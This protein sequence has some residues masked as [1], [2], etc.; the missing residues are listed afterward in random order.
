MATRSSARDG[1]STATV[2]RI[3]VTVVATLVV[4]YAVY[5]VRS[6]LVLVLV[7][8]FLAAGL[9]PAVRRL[10]GFGLSRGA[11][12]GTIFLAA[13]A[14]LVAFAMAV[15]PPLARQVA[16]FARDFPDY[17][18]D[19]A[20]DNT[21]L[22]DWVTENQLATRL[23]KAVGQIPSTIGGSFG[24]I[25]GFA[26]S[27]L[28]QLFNVL[29]VV[30]LTIYF[31]LSLSRI[32]HGSL[33]LVPASRRERVA[34]LLDP[35]LEKIG[36]YIAGQVTVAL[37][38]GAL[39]FVFLAI[40]GVPFPVALALWVSIAALIP[41]VGATLGA[42]PAVIVAFFDS[43]TVGIA[44]LVYF[45]VYQQVENY[46]IAPRVMTKAVDISPAAVLLAALVGG[47]MLGFVGALMAI[48]AAASIKLVA[49]QVVLPRLERA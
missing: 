28:G 35:V 40:A 8:A 6:V 37:V 30:I 32:R 43:T 45:V 26:G 9:D 33:R 48:P 5:L 3:V 19:I 11:A 42:I 46:V 47:S 36:G 25:L 29:T 27:V 39:A 14:F 24:R 18:R 17:V 22:S 16:D 13:L 41:L 44:T 23:E 12:V 31:L 49:Q 15:V 10:E 1:P 4:L 38:A 34:A 20:Q 2:V 21:L 7:A